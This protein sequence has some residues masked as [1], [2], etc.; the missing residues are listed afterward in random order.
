MSEPYDPYLPRNGSSSNAAGSSQGNPKTAA[1]QQ[2][3]D[4][5]VGIMRENIT[6]V[7]ER[8]ERLDSLQDKT[9]NLA[10]SA[11]GFRRG[12][13]RVRKNMWWKDMKMRLII[14][15]AVAIII[16]IIVVAIVKTTKH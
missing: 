11:Q 8:G 4:D 13:N 12:A 14:G 5:T 10:V 15:F 3:I 16:I 7:A 6:K 9:D 1:I 2:Q